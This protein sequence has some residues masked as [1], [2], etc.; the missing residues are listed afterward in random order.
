[1][2]GQAKQRSLKKTEII[3]NAER[4]VYCD[5]PNPT[6]IEH[7]PPRGLFRNKDRPSGWEFACCSS[8]NQE[9]RGSD[10]VAQ[11]LAFVDPIN[12]TEPE[13]SWKLQAMTKVTGAVDAHAPGVL[14]EIFDY[15]SWTNSL[16]RKRGLIHRVRQSQAS[17]IQTKF[18]LDRFSAKFG[19]ASFRHFTGRE[20]GMN[21]LIF[22]QWYLNAGLSQETFTAHLSILPGHHELTQGTKT[23]GEQFSVWFNT[24]KKNITAVLGTFHSNLFIQ[25]IC[26]DGEEFIGPLRETL[27]S[28]VSAKFP[29]T[30]LVSASAPWASMSQRVRTALPNDGAGGLHEMRR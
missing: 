21:G 25:C 6:T 18:H 28:M 14:K 10:A 23:S 30:N 7:M 29:T 4:C 5:D 16:V 17:G 20:L 22:T 11:L 8:C 2:V 15:R 13:K 1:M 24:D 27:G 19:M 3:Q 9:T 26:T 12:I